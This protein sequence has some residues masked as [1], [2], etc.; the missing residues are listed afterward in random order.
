MA[1]IRTT[2]PGIGYTSA[3]SSGKIT[4][5][6][7]SGASTVINGGLS[8]QK[9]VKKESKKS[10]DNGFKF[11]SETVEELRAAFPNNDHMDTLI[12]SNNISDIMSYIGEVKNLKPV[13]HIDTLDEILS[14]SKGVAAL[15]ELSTYI[16]GKR[17][18][19]ALYDKLEYLRDT[20]NTQRFKS[21]PSWYESTLDRMLKKSLDSE[22]T[23]SGDRVFD[24]FIVNGTREEI[25]SSNPERGIEHPAVENY[26]WEINDGN[27]G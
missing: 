25:A 5:R 26:D 11:G 18:D 20:F 13:I 9:E 8:D 23:I 1:E 14:N 10:E 24:D 16:E 27:R 3:N 6:R 2:Y 22:V 4:S 19:I 15:S 17:S 21:T 7:F 12:E